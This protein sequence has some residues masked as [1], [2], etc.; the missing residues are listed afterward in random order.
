MNNEIFSTIQI[1][2]ENFKIIDNKH[3]NSTN[4]T[5]YQIASCSKF[6]T[7]IVVGKLYELG[8]LDYDTDI[9]KY[10]KKWK[11]PAKNITLRTLLNHTSG[12]NDR[13]GYLG[14]EPFTLKKDLPTNIETINGEDCH[15][16][17][18]FVEKPGKIEMYSGA[19][20]QVIQQVLEEITG[21]HLYQLMNQYIFRPLKLT[22]STG[23]ILYPIF[24]IKYNI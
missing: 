21:K 14:Y 15:K 19:G 9:N 17:V 3:F 8:K 12:T 16:G 5:V 13:L 20:Y 18:N 2:T 22:N 24:C 23:K 1:K 7:S 4:N 11:C 10:L 6:I